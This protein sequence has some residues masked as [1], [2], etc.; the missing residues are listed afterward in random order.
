MS[1]VELAAGRQKGALGPSL[2]KQRE[3]EPSPVLT[4]VAVG[5]G[6]S[7]VLVVILPQVVHV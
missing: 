7:P 3:K 1:S 4:L 2:L 6:G 5:L